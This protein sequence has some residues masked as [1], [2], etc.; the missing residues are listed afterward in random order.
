MINLRI[1][2]MGSK[3][4]IA[5]ELIY[6]MIEYK[7]KAKYF[8]DLF[9]G[10]GSMSFAALQMGYTVIYNEYDSDLSNFVSFLMDRIVSGERS[11]YGLLPT[12][13]YQ[14]VTREEFNKQKELH[15]PYAEFCKIVYSFGNN[16][17]AYLFNL[18][19]EKIK[20]LAHDFVVFNC[21][22]SLQKYN[23]L[24]GINLI[25]PVGDSINDRRLNYRKQLTNLLS[26]RKM[27]G[28]QLQQLEQLER[29]EQLEQ[30]QS[31]QQLE[32]LTILNKSYNEVDIP[33]NC[34][35]V[36]IYCDPPYRGTAEYLKE[37]NYIKFDNW[38]KNNDKTIFISEYNAPFNII[39]SVD[40][41]CT[42][43][44]SSNNKVVENLYINKDIKLGQLSL[45]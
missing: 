25:M 7:P 36:I 29:L 33:Y 4:L 9:G 34:D 44:S 21:K 26:N 30:L 12:E 39:H 28:L 31:L 22:N 17:Q 41:R 3:N 1:P 14:F 18:E 8:Y 20:H 16:R 35:E 10:G 11:E 38:V 23:K 6:K 19:I 24:V 32:R 45:F 42:L 37:F 13:W 2:Y 27:E 15:T 43:S 5:E 40:K